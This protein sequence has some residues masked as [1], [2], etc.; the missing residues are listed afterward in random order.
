MITI[1]I[2]NEANFLAYFLIFEIIFKFGLADRC[3]TIVLQIHLSKWYFG[4]SWLYL[5]VRGRMEV[6]KLVVGRVLVGNR[7]FFV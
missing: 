7:L 3:G 2:L 4:V 6:V 1:L 5:L